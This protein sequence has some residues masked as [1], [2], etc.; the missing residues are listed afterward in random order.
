LVPAGRAEFGLEPGGCV[1]DVAHLVDP[2]V[3]D[4]QQVT[5]GKRDRIVDRTHPAMLLIGAHA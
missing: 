2:E 1:E 5:T 4:A 3:G